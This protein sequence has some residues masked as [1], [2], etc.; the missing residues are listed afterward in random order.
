LEEAARDDLPD[1]QVREAVQM[2]IQK[3]REGRALARMAIGADPPLDPVR[4]SIEVARDVLK[5]L[6]IEAARAGVDL[7]LRDTPAGYVVGSIALT[8]AL[9][10]VLLNAISFSPAGGSIELSVV[11]SGTRVQFRVVDQGPGIADGEDPFSGVS[12][13]PG[14]AGIGLRHARESVRKLGGEIELLASKSGAQ[15]EIS[16]PRHLVVRGSHTRPSISTQIRSIISGRRILVVEDDRSVCELLEVGLGARGAELICLHDE[17]SLRERLSTLGDLDV[18][19]LDL[20]PIAAHLSDILFLLRA[21]F[22][23]AAIIFMSG[24]TELG[25]ELPRA[26]S[27]WIRKP[28]DLTEITQVIAEV[29]Q[30]KP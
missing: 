22:E 25:I 30:V 18:I 3:A 15:F 7:Q 5:S 29:L 20:S 6:S 27:R 12:T 24:S 9:T 21:T 17:M 23:R 26:R 11:E 4:P 1:W 10:N 19:L 14:G 2:A 13:R 28:F 8:Q 16:V